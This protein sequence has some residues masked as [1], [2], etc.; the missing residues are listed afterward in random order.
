MGQQIL[1]ISASRGWIRRA[2]WPLSLGRFS[3]VSRP[4]SSGLNIVP[5]K[6]HLPVRERK[7]STD[8]GD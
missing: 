2:K 5:A 6:N 7:R 8:G 4:K 1:Q 3:V